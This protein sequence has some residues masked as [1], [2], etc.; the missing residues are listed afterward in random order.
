M[1]RKINSD[2]FSSDSDDKNK[3][4]KIKLNSCQ[5]SSSAQRLQF[6]DIISFHGLVV[7]KKNQSIGFLILRG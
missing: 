1:Q 6:L 3:L 7:M 4:F 2:D 5:S